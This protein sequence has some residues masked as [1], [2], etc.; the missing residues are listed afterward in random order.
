MINRFLLNNLNFFATPQHL[1]SS[2]TI[3]II[4]LLNC[5]EW[6][7]GRIQDFSQGGARYFRN[8]KNPKG[9]TNFARSAN[10]FICARSARKIFR[11]PLSNFR[12][13][14][15]KN[16]QKMFLYFSILQYFN[17]FSL[18]SHLL[19]VENIVEV[20][21]KSF[22]LN[23]TDLENKWTI[24][25]IYMFINIK[26]WSWLAQKCSCRRQGTKFFVWNVAEKGTKNMMLLLLCLVLGS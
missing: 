7:Q 25:N 19:L 8:K 4:M 2:C 10:T 5:Y 12:T 18:I 9:T 15:R 24:M 6:L 21:H 11:P 26:Y 14:L 23:N 17:T 22:L 13:P 1:L 16:R 3:E 20:L